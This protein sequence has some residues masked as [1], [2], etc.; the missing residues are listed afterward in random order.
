MLHGSSSSDDFVA[1][2]ENDDDAIAPPGD[3][4][5]LHVSF[6]THAPAIP[7][8]QNLRNIVRHAL[9]PACADGA[10]AVDVG[11]RGGSGDDSHAVL[12]V[13]KR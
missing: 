8:T 1:L 3:N 5:A 11:V 4:I 9:T 10:N 2:A 12:Y 13:H 7:N 6:H